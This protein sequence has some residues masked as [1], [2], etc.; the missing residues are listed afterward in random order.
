MSQIEEFIN[1]WITSGSMQVSHFAWNDASKTE[2]TT[3]CGKIILLKNAIVVINSR[4][5]IPH[6][7]L[8]IKSLGKQSKRSQKQ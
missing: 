5:E 8:C 4:S 3:A 2:I 7:K 1:E 6:C